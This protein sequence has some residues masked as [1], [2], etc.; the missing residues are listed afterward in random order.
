MSKS[1]TLGQGLPS[2]TLNPLPGQV[3]SSDPPLPPPEPA[4]SGN[5]KNDI[6]LSSISTSQLTEHF[7]IHYLIFNW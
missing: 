5:H 6:A 2:L 4:F 7:L 1:M 3:V